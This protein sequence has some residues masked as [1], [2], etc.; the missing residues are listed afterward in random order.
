MPPGPWGYRAGTDSLAGDWWAFSLWKPTLPL[1]MP[2]F[3]PLLCRHRLAGRGPP[4]R[5]QPVQRWACRLRVSHDVLRRAADAAGRRRCVG[6]S[7]V[8]AMLSALCHAWVVRAGVANKALP[9]SHSQRWLPSCRVQDHQR[10]AL[11][12]PRDRRGSLGQPRCSQA[13]VA[14]GVLACALTS[15]GAQCRFVV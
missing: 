3:S 5:V 12:G 13:N 14:A 8:C 10:G 15:A 2:F 11:L 1:G 7:P 6:C 9:T 4:G